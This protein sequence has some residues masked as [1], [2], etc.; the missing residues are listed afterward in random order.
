MPDGSRKSFYGITAEEAENLAERFM[1]PSSPSSKGATLREFVFQQFIPTVEGHSRKWR[2]QIAWALDKHILERYGH[3]P[4]ADITRSELQT[5]L[6]QKLRTLS[7][8]SV[9]HIRKILHQVLALAEADD[10]IHKNPVPHVKLPPQRQTEPKPVPGFDELKGMLSAVN[11]PKAQ[12]AVYLAC[13]LGL[14]KGEV[15]GLKWA[16]IQQGGFVRVC[17]QLD[18]L[19]ALSPLKTSSSRRTIPVPEEWQKGLH[20]H[21]SARIVPLSSQQLKDRLQG[22]TRMH[23]LRHAFATNIEAIGCPRPITQRILGHSS[24]SVTDLYVHQMETLT[25][26]W[27]SRYLECLLE[28]GGKVGVNGLTQNPPFH[29]DLSSKERA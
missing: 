8:A 6:N 17:R 4:I 25:R 16:D 27:L 26:E 22:I 15:L 24:K 13:T 12:N 23:D 3:Y 21:A 1:R 29:P 2:E 5:F 10:L 11:D 7:R 19:G 18:D 20:R 14:R 28:S 9:G